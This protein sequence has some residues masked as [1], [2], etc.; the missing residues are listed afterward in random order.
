MFIVNYDVSLNK[1]NK[2]LNFCF[3]IKLCLVIIVSVHYQTLLG[4]NL[5]FFFLNTSI[6]STSILTT[7]M[8]STSI[9]RTSILSASILSTSFLS[10]SILCAS[11]L[12]ASILCASILTMS[13]LNYKYIF[14]F[15][16]I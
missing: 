4:H 2:T 11:I 7:S 10:S 3:R 8:L 6:L 5:Y 9:L 12:C 1:F 16:Q 13:C 15:Y 14:R